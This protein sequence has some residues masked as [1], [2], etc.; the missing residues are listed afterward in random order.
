ME[1]EKAKFMILERVLLRFYWGDAKFCHA[2][3]LQQLGWWCIRSSFSDSQSVSD[4]D[5]W[6][7]NSLPVPT[8]LWEL[9]WWCCN[10]LGEN[11]ATHWI[12]LEICHYVR[13]G[14][15][16]YFSGYVKNRHQHI[17][18][19][20]YMF[21]LSRDKEKMFSRFSHRKCCSNIIFWKIISLA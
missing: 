8:D 20:K 10:I 7:P 2:A 15:F 13:L 16:E 3:G 21:A 1:L 17:H 9:G 18:S 12:S 19:T 6:S 4:V 11:S 5:Q 14:P